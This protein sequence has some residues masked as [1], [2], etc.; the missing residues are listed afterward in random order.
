[1]VCEIE[2]PDMATSRKIFL[3]FSVNILG[4]LNGIPK[5]CY[6]GDNDTC[7]PKTLKNPED[8]MTSI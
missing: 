5:I 3:I 8:L 6:N 4:V 7:N 2:F 1:M